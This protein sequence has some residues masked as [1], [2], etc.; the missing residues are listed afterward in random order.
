MFERHSEAI[1]ELLREDEDID[2]IRLADLR[3]EGRAAG[4]SL[5]DVVIDGGWME[6]PVLLAKVAGHL[7]CGFVAEVP[8]VLPGEVVT[9]LPGALARAYGVVP[10]RAAGH[11][12]DILAADPF[13]SE[14][15]SELNF[16][17]GRQVHL[18]V[19]DPAKVELLIKQH[20]GEDEA[21]PDEVLREIDVDEF[22]GADGAITANDLKTMAGQTPIVRFVN[23]VL[24][25]AIRDQASD[26]HF[27][28]SEQEFKI[29]YR[30]DGVLY[31]MTPPSKAL[32]LPITSRIKVLANLDIAERRVP[33]DG[34]IR[35][36]LAGRAVDLRV[37][38]LPT[39]FGESVVL[40]VLDQSAVQLEL[41]ALGMPA[42]VQAG[43]QQII[44][45]PN[46]I[47]LVT[48]PTGS[49]K[50]TTLYSGLRAINQPEL[51]LLTIEDPVEYELEGVMQV[52][53]NPAA[54]LTFASALRSFLRQDPDVIMVGEIR[55]L[56]TA[57]IAI[58]ASLTGH[59]VL[60]TLHTNDAVSAVTRLRDMGVAPFLLASTVE[61]VLAQRLVRRICP[62]CRTAGEP[63]P[64]LLAQLGVAGASLGNREVF[65]G[66]GCAHCS[67]TGYRGR[68]GI[69]E[70]LVLSEPL[71]ELVAAGAP[72]HLIRQS[73]REQGMRSLRAEGLR[74]VFDGATT[75]EEILSYT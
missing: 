37:S 30:V 5:A 21:R 17:L 72:A 47:F 75:L 8:A 50:T 24:A 12:G 10:L 69:F 27:E 3:E 7:G 22:A 16:A 25:Q 62:H 19:G 15:A 70:W 31:E 73:A 41:A 63:A 60:S 18:L 55:D 43:V 53:I 54:R 64:A 39:Q 48:G 13:A 61:A 51:K 49:G 52:P 35:I 66:R 11:D 33:Q 38:T 40:R 6:K 23:L 29:R 68:M 26:I 34:R 42:D 56:E 58:Q 59:L 4:R 67:G 32:A 14:T 57:Q 46:G 2:P 65:R 28:P 1:Y 9:L 74:A 44:R 36:S 45:R 20:Y 71:R